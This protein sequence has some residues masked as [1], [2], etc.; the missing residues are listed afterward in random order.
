VVGGQ[1]WWRPID[2]L[3]VGLVAVIVA[4]RI[5]K[6]GGIVAADEAGVVVVV[7]VAKL[8][9]AFVVGGLLFPCFAGVDLV[10]RAAGAGDVGCAGVGVL[11]ADPVL[12]GLAGFGGGDIAEI[13]G[14]DVTAVTVGGDADI[15]GSVVDVVGG[16]G[17]VGVLVGDGLVGAENPDTA[18]DER[19]R[20]QRTDLALTVGS[21][22]SMIS[23]R[24]LP[25]CIPGTRPRAELAGAARSVRGL[26][27]SGGTRANQA[28]AGP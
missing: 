25:T 3:P 11:G 15:G 4:E 13:R 2:Q 12:A 16:D 14:K 26:F 20:C 7:P 24:G 10:D 22:R 19:D 21:P 18:S 23:R 6:L 27:R 28:S 5:G 9:G 1:G 17:P 8:G